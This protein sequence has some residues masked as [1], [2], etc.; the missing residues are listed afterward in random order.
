M[1]QTA[2]LRDFDAQ[3][4]AA[5]FGSGLAD[6]ATYVAN[7]AA[8]PAQDPVPCTVLVDRDVTDFGDDLAPVSVPVVLVTFQRAE[9]DPQAGDAGAQVTLTATGEVFDLIRRVRADESICRWEVQHVQ[10]A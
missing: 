4:I 9:V 2:F 8:D 5:F 1:S 7:P 10:P 6:A 3:A